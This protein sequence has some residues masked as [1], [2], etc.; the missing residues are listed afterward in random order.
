MKNI[1]SIS[2][3]LFVLIGCKSK[4]EKL[5]ADNSSVQSFDVKGL[6][7]GVY[8]YQLWNE[9]QKVMIK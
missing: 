1:I 4:S 6:T 3:I 5:G 2:F 9:N 8:F 7:T